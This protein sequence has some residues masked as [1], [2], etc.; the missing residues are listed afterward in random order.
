VEGVDFW[1]NDIKDSLAES[2]SINTE[3]RMDLMSSK[4]KKAYRPEQ[5]AESHE[6]SRSQTYI[7]IAAGRLIARKVGNRT[8]I[9]EEDAEAWRRALPQM[10][11]RSANPNPSEHSMAT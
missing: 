4:P 9:L 1:I 11:A 10:A 3:Q 6:I 2:P 7:E 5:F 8:L